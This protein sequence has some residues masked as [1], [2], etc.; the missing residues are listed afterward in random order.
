MK[1]KLLLASLTFVLALSG[2]TTLTS[3]KFDKTLSSNR[4]ITQHQKAQ[5]LARLVHGVDDI[6]NS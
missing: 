3:T 4:A 1:T 2:G 6:K 5:V